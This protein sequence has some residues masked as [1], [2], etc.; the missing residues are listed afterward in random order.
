[1]NPAV[2]CFLTTVD[3]VQTVL[4]CVVEQGL[5]VVHLLSEEPWGVSRFFYRDS[6]GD[7]HQ[8][9]V[10]YLSATA[11]L[12]G[13]VGE[14]A[15]GG[16]QRIRL[17]G[18]ATGEGDG[19]V[20]VEQADGVVPVVLDDPPG[21]LLPAGDIDVSGGDGSLVSEE[22]QAAVDVDGVGGG[23]RGYSGDD[24]PDGALRLV[25]GAELGGDTGD[26]K[27]AD[28]DDRGGQGEEVGC[29]HGSSRYGPG[30]GSRSN[31]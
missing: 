29:S 3:E 9:R 1:M 23:V 13:V 18:R 24:G 4:G 25:L 7:G 2:S 8:R 22:Q 10:A 27:S 30:S 31:P 15:V 5:E 12:V 28:K 19:D 14:V 20:D 6:A 26:G 11:P 16:G 21:L 17:G